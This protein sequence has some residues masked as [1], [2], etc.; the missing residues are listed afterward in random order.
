MEKGQVYIGWK[1]VGIMPDRKS[2]LMGQF[3]ARL[4]RGVISPLTATVLAMETRNAQ[5]ESIDQV[6]FVSCDLVEAGFNEELKARLHG[7]T[8][9]LELDKLTV[10]VTHTHSAPCI[11][12]G[13]YEEPEDEPDFMPPAEYLE[14]LTERLSEAVAGAW[15]ER[16][17]G[18]VSCGFDYA[19]VGHCRRAVYLDGSARMYG[20]TDRDD[21]AGFEGYAD[22]AVNMLFTWDAAQ[23]LSGVVVNVACP[24][25]CDESSYEYSA[26]YWHHVREALAAR[27]GKKVHLLP[28]CAPSGDMSPHLLVDGAAEQAL[29]QRTGLDKKGL[30]AKRLMT[31]IEA[32]WETARNHVQTHLELAHRPELISLPLLQVTEEEYALEQ[33]TAVLDEE[34][35]KNLPYMFQRLWPF[36]LVCDLRQRYEY[37][38]THKERAYE[39]H[40]VRVG[41]VV[42]ATNAFELYQDFGIRLRGRS[43]ALQTFVVQLSDSMD[44][45]YLPTQ[46]ALEGGHYSAMIKSNWVGPEGG[47]LLVDRTI[48]VVDELF[49]GEPYPKTR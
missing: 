8:P 6:V 47:T 36:G 14:W 5:G 7:R 26:D 39:C 29:R 10:S 44:G 49:A 45:F 24:A 40:I 35:R 4:S 33:Q 31:A 12:S 20:Q 19:V 17:A 34:S 27:F 43:K 48:A 13:W 42:F 38:K 30:I 1:K 9:G 2:L 18:G 28:L 32:G 41:E 21:F 22:H 23:Q 46:R 15:N 11:S 16:Q 37:Q 3:H 25:Q